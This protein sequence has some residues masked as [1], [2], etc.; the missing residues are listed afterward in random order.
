MENL[1]ES[2][3]LALAILVAGGTR[4]EAATAAD[5]AESTI[6]RWLDDAA[7]SHCLRDAQTRAYSDSINTIKSASL[8]AVQTLCA[9]AA[10]KGVSASARVSAASAILS[11]CFKAVEQTEIQTRLEALQR[12]LELLGEK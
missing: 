9:V 10:D 8:L 12:Q 4:A 11:N 5:V 2:Q 6:Y 3:L 1:S 7:F